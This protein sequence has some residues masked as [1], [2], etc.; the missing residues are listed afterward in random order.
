MIRVRDREEEE[1]AR[2][3]WR[4]LASTSHYSYSRSLAFNS[5]ESAEP[6]L[7]VSRHTARKVLVTS[8]RAARA[9]RRRATCSPLYAPSIRW[10]EERTGSSRLGE[11]TRQKPVISVSPRRT[12]VEGALRKRRKSTGGCS[13]LTQCARCT[14]VP[15]INVSMC[16]PLLRG[17][18]AAR[19]LRLGCSVIDFELRKNETR[20]ADR[21]RGILLV[22]QNPPFVPPFVPP[23]NF[24]G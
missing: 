11:E 4:K 3:R 16:V 18:P 23:S 21:R 20:R 12:F 1:D 22:A 14:S 7:S 13:P 8:S 10:Q 17:V 24:L 9:D 19:L 6:Y 15:P 2:R 5:G